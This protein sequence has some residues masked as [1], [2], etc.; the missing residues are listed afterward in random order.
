MYDIVFVN[1]PPAV[2]FFLFRPD[3][4]LH[5][6]SKILE[7]SSTEKRVLS[8][9]HISNYGKEFYRVRRKESK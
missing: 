2:N 5:Q 1:K 8:Q 9:P 6:H 4:C 7:I 3:G